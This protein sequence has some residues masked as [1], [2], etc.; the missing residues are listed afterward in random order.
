MKL[1]G[2]NPPVRGT[3]ATALVLGGRVDEG[4]ALAK[5]M[6][7]RNTEP[8]RKS[9]NAL[10]LALGY[11]ARGNVAEGRTFVEMAEK[12]DPECLFLPRVRREFSGVAQ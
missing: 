11:K 7:D 5:E 8:E 3:R 4:M 10:A 2:W 6:I 12:L 9:F 1:V